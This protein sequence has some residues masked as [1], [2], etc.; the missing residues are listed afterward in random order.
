MRWCSMWSSAA[1]LWLRRMLGRPP[2]SI[3]RV[4]AVGGGEVAVHEAAAAEQVR[5]LARG[6]AAVDDEPEQRLRDEAERVREAV[7]V[8]R[9]Q[10]ARAGR[11][12][13]DQGRRR[14]RP[15]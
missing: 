9:L 1:F 3:G 12:Y 10:R 11:R 6:G 4:A 5:G 15:D 13:D 14:R 2:A 8:V 7:Q